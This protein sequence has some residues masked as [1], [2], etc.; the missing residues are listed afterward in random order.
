MVRVH[1]TAVYTVKQNKTGRGFRVLLS[2]TLTVKNQTSRSA[3]STKP[4]TE[5]DSITVTHML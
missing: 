3:S 1:L 5:A 4:P 2:D